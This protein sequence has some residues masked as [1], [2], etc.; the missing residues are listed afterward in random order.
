MISHVTQDVRT[1]LRN[2]P[3]AVQEQAARAYARWR[4]DPYHPSLDVK[5][6]SQRQPISSVRVGMGYRA[7]GLREHD[8][9]YWFWIGPHREYDL[10]LTRL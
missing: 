7:L 2:L 3:S 6:V 9:L 10:F 4:A 5:R 1:R 8:E